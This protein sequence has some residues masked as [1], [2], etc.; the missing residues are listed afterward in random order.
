MYSSHTSWRRLG[1]L[2]LMGTFI[3]GHAVSAPCVTDLDRLVVVDGLG[4]TLSLIDRFRD[5]V[6]VG[7]RTLGAC[8]NRIR[9]TGTDLL[10]VNSCSDDLWV[11]NRTD[12]TLERA[13]TFPD[14]DNPYDVAIVDDSLCA[15]SMLITNDVAV[16]NYRTGAKGNHLNVGTSP[17]AILALGRR[18][19]VANTGFD[20][21]TFTFGPGTVTVLNV[22]LE[23]TVATIPVG[24]NPQGLVVAPDGTVH[25][26]CTGNYFDQFGI[27][28]ILDPV[29]L[30][31]IDSLPVGGSPGDVVIGS[32][33]AGYLAAG[34]FVDSGLVY[35]YDAITRQVLNGAGNPWKTAEGVIAVAPRVEGGVYCICFSADSVTALNPNGTQA[36]AWQVGDG[37]VHAAL[38]TN[39][40]PGD[41]NE[42]QILNVL[43]VVGVIGVAFRGAPLPPR[44]GSGD[45]NGD[46][47]YDILD[48]VKLID[49]VFR[50][51]IGL[52]WGCA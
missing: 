3:L 15:V 22:D 46:C 19:W 37:P 27:L 29:A 5:S 38:L 47:V 11:L 10:V 30:T 34:G 51:G 24:T 14:G 20:F 16:V 21:G 2:I 17:Q 4:E 42:D 44:P 1:F 36:G 28:Y 39:R 18:L 41:L 9:D 25:V 50:G 48:V 23:S 31:V 52:R 6:A 26:L 12:F 8:P 43:D 32:D 40:I 35:R 33:G 13:V 7:V 49:V 45:V